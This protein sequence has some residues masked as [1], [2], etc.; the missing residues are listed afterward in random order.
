[1]SLA[2][3]ALTLP[4]AKARGFTATFVKEKCYEFDEIYDNCVANEFFFACRAMEILG[5]GDIKLTDIVEK[6]Q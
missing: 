3:V 6:E 4:I 2:E 1:M 5:I